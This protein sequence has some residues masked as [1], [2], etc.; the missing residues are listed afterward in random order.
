MKEW[1]VL[2]IAALLC[3]GVQAQGAPHPDSSPHKV[4]F[5]TVDANVK[6]EVLDW[7]G[8]GKPLVFLAGLGDTGHEFDELA[9]EF[10]N[11]NHVYAITRRG[12]G[13]SSKPAPTKENY[14]TGRLGEDV[15][16]AID[17]LRLKAPILAGHSLAGEELSWVGTHHPG[18]VSG[19][20]YLEAGYSYAYYAPGNSI[21][22]GT[23]LLLS[24]D[25]LEK[26]LGKLRKPDAITNG[27]A[28]NA[29]M[30]EIKG[31]LSD[32]E[33]DLT[34]AQH[35]LEILPPPPAPLKP[36]PK[37]LDDKI[38][39][40]VLAGPEKFS[41]IRVPILALFSDPPEA[42]P[43]FHLTKKIIDAES[44]R[45]DRQA[46]AFA[47]GIPWAHVVKIPNAAHDLWKTNRADVVRE[48][49]GF[50]ATLN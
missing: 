42:P 49:K 20:I 6:L 26:A 50:L 10:V 3:T 32:F 27:R 47:A 1:W 35:Q 43:N 17:A 48:M 24:G 9:L 7:G 23:N 31:P 39:D 11:S 34:E 44:A 22:L 33:K 8:T 29:L 28:V 18:K 45:W 19:L 40:A 4:E 30:S 2:A 13:N 5:V 41:P 21:P 46:N 38:S 15:I 16:E 25:A 36:A 37:T 12:F 14:S